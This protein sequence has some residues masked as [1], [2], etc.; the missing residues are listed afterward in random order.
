MYI[1]LIDILAGLSTPEDLRR[2]LLC[3]NELKC[4]SK[5]RR[6]LGQELHDKLQIDYILGC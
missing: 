1:F 6:L 3:T 5:D 2:L 4:L